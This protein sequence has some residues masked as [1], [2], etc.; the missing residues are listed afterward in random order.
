MKRQSTTSFVILILVILSLTSCDLF[1]K[2]E[3]I[4]KAKLIALMVAGYDITKENTSGITDMSRL[5]FDNTSFN[6]DISGWDVS[7]VTNMSEMFSGA[8]AFNGDIS[9]WE[10][11]KVTNMGGMFSG[12][13][14]FNGDISSWDVSNVISYT[15]FSSGCPL[16]TEYHPDFP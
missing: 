2:K 16:I 8:T 3:P 14:A 7:N 6:Q 11:S 15:D 12:A 4:T 5:F 1:M 13:T 9:S 10:V